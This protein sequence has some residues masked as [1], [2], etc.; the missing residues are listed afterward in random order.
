MSLKAIWTWIG[1]AFAACGLCVTAYNYGGN[2]YEFQKKLANLDRISGLEERLAR[3]EARAP[4][5]AASLGPQGAE[6]PRGPEGRPGRQGEAGPQGERGPVGPKGEP[7]TTPAQIA[8]FEK[9]LAMLE[10]RPAV[11][12]ASS[13]N[14]QV[15]TA[16]PADEVSM[17]TGIRRN[18]QGCFY[19][20]PDF[21]VGSGVF[22][23]D[24]KFCT[25]DGQFG[26]ILTR[27]ADDKVGYKN[28]YGQRDCQVLG[29]SCPTGFAS[30]LSWTPKRVF[31][32]SS[33]HL[34]VEIAWERR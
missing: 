22:E 31:M 34:K 25:I 17:P 8:D 18:A 29:R 3:L 5:G 7:G 26:L 6:G 16:G 27:I 23:V 28:Q 15:A 19:F 20:T 30:N 24:D 13:A 1:G 21:V 11:T 2:V 9:R 32:D 33:S 10:R 12:G 4:G 14:T